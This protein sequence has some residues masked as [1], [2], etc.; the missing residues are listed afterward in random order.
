MTTPPVVSVVI[1]T[2]QRADRLERLVA[3]L[4]A[5]TLDCSRFEVA[6]VDDC[7]TDDTAAILA[8]LADST[9]L[10]LRRLQTESNSGGPSAPR[11]LGWRAS[12]AP[13]IAF[14][15]DDCFPEPEWLAAGV[16]AMQAHPRWGLCQGYTW[17]ELRMGAG[18]GGRWVV[19]RTVTESTCWFEAAN[20]FYRRAALEAVQGFDERIKTWGED[21]DLG[22]RVVEAGW[23][24]GYERDAVGLHEVIDRGW[25]YAAKFGWLDYQTIAVAARHPQIRSRG[26]WRPWALQRQGAEFALAFAGLLLSSRWRP[27]ALAAAPY[28]VCNRPPFRRRGVNR[29]TITL[30]LQIVAV[31]SVRF[32]AHVRGSI[33]S[34]MFVL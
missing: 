31:D 16:A 20:I 28:L 8:K 4:S 25:K 23:E 7:S 29:E 2:F 34:R 11:N 32:A 1:P 22:W 21:T 14:L 15:D 13:I 27:A 26:F 3:A 17:P 18:P 6:I 24:A 12:S 5:Q 33:A 30:G 10:N 19:S 9:D